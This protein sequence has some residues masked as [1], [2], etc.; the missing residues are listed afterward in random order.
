MPGVGGACPQLAQALSTITQMQQEN[1]K[2]EAKEARQKESPRRS[3]RGT[4]TMGAGHFSIFPYYFNNETTPAVATNRS[5]LLTNL[6]CI[7]LFVDCRTSQVESLHGRRSRSSSSKGKMKEEGRGHL[8]PPRLI[9]LIC[10]PTQTRSQ[11]GGRCCP[12]KPQTVSS[13]K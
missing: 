11:A 6:S 4:D 10:Q 12:P 13:S 2:K 5:L 8:L 3:P 1:E 9:R 7:P